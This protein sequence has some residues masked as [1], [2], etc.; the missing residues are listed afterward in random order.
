M[1]V[2]VSQN[3]TM[4]FEEYAMNFP[5]FG[6]AMHEYRSS[7]GTGHSDTILVVMI[8]PFVDHGIPVRRGTWEIY[9][10]RKF[11]CKQLFSVIEFGLLVDIRCRNTERERLT[12]RASI[13]IQPT[14]QERPTTI[15]GDKQWSPMMQ[16][17][18]RG[19]FLFFINT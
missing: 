7:F 12:R 13:G 8:H 5:C 10:V 18:S 17:Y 2:V 3:V 1:C 6:R 14:F 19:R 11:A 15:V 9:R 4:R 16:T